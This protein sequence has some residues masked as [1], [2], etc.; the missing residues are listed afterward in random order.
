MS[1]GYE[2]VDAW[3]TPTDTILPAGNF[4]VEI[5]D[6][7]TEAETSGHNPQLIVRHANS[8]GR[9]T[10]WI[11]ITAKSMGKIAQVFDVAG[12]QRPQE[13]EFDPQTGKL[14]PMCAARLHGRWVGVVIRDEE[15]FKDRT[16]MRPRVQGY[17]P[18]GK[19]T[20]E[21]APTTQSSSAP[22]AAQRFSD[23]DIPFHHEDVYESTSLRGHENR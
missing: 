4:V 12:V 1:F 16:R 13:G 19:I 18:K 10:N 21:S 9:T 20:G 2:Q 5:T 8:Q 6:T 22:A 3:E 11:V 17:V 15:D 7:D 23:T 14:T